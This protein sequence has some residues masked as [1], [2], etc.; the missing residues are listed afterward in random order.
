MTIQWY[1]FVGTTGVALCLLAYFQLQTSRCSS[2]DLQY[3][4]LNLVGSL[5]IG[6]TL[7][8]DFNLSA[9]IIEVC[10]FAISIY[11]VCSFYVKKSN[12][13]AC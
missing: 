11:G 7:L 9:L 8:Y 6:V 10:W 3:S 13:E 4:V 1:D 2:F 5:L 12:A